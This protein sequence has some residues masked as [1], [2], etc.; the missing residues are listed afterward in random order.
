[1]GFGEVRLSLKVRLRDDGKHREVIR[2]DQIVLLG[3]PSV[4][5]HL[6]EITGVEASRP[7]DLWL[8]PEL[9]RGRQKLGTWVPRGSTPDT[10]TPQRY[11]APPPGFPD[12][13]PLR[14]LRVEAHFLSTG[15]RTVTNRA[16]PL[17]S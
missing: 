3:A 6:G 13:A 15:E 4:S 5:G 10:G 8:W 14:L 16:R 2:D 1:M 7:D 11:A 9:P 12:H 17:K